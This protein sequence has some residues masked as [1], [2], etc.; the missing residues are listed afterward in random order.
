MR[1]GILTARSVD[2]MKSDPDHRKEIPDG[3]VPGLYLVVQPSGKKSWALRTRIAGRPVKITLG[4]VS[5]DFG[6]ASARKAARKKIEAIQDGE[7]PRSKRSTEPVSLPGTV[8]ELCDRYVKQYLRKQVRRWK[9]AEGEIENHIRPRLGYLR[10]DQ[11]ERVHVREMLAAI[12][13]DYPVAANR[14]LQR[15][16]AVFNWAI[17]NDLAS[18]NPTLGIKRPTRETPVSRTLSDNDLAAI[19]ESCVALRYPGCE[20]V[21]F[22]I[23]SGQRRDDVRLMH[24]REI[25][26]ARGDW[27]IPAERYKSRRAHL[28]PLTNAMHEILDAMPF[29]DNGGY[30]LSPSGGKKPYG[31]VIRPKAALER[32]TGVTGWT[33]H[34]LRRTMR[35]GLSRLGIRPDISERVIGHSVGGSL[36][37]VYDT[38][39]FRAEKLAALEAWHVHVVAAVEGQALANVVPIR[40]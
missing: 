39:E 14:A 31:N 4:K 6:P 21:R 29:R 38:H 33:L 36:G 22:L 25:D 27:V 28:I 11:I 17:E 12:A 7:D 32:A 34:D 40:A 10:L 37:Q 13:P 20:L 3:V 19:W 23:L 2:A 18:R 26:M 9:A 5:I 30:I 24:W 15:L 8:G 16:R 1:T 35:T